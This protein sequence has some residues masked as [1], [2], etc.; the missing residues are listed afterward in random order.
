MPVFVLYTSDMQQIE[1]GN[2]NEINGQYKDWFIGSFVE[3][4][5]FMN[6]SGVKNFEAKWSEH[7][8]G[9]VYPVKDK[10][11]SDDSCKSMV[12]LINGKFRYSFINGD[13]GFNDYIMVMSGDYITWTPDILHEI[14]A[15]DDS[16]TL[17]IR[18]YS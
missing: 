2:V 9:V 1:V 11:G 7:E 10:P 6:S 13:N 14:E 16:V 4:N 8:K 5:S 12:I 17:T 18:W 3:S 15:L